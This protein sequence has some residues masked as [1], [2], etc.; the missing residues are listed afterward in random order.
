MHA[1][2]VEVTDRNV[3]RPVAFLSG[4]AA[5]SFARHTLHML[6]AGQ[7]VEVHAAGLAAI[8]LIGRAEPSANAIADKDQHVVWLIYR[9]HEVKE[10]DVIIVHFHPEMIRK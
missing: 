4:C 6:M 8:R 2:H 1:H 10:L 3:S 5:V 9:V 7:T